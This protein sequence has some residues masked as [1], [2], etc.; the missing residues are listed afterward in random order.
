MTMTIAK[1]RTEEQEGRF[2]HI[3]IIIITKVSQDQG[4]NTNHTKIGK[5]ISAGAISLSFVFF[6]FA[7]RKQTIRHPNHVPFD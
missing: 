6:N 2:H 7:V 1:M 4:F 3:I 5:L